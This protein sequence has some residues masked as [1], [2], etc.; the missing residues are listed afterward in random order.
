MSYQSIVTDSLPNDM[1]DAGAPWSE[2]ELIMHTHHVSIYRDKFPVSPGHMLFVPRYNMVKLL[3][4]AFEEAFRYGQMRVANGEWD[5]FNVGLNWGDAAGQTVPWP[6]IHLIPR[7]EGDVADP[8]GGVRAV[9]QN[10]LSNYRK[11][12]KLD[13]NGGN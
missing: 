9:L 8:V 13:P 2:A 3:C 11:G 7:Y 1:D 6:H 5:A 10:G 12:V 4:E